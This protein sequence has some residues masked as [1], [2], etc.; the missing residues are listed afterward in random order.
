MEKTSKARNNLKSTESP[1][2]DGK[3][4][5]AR[6]TSKARENLKSTG[7]PQKHGKPLKSTGKPQKH[8][9][10]SIAREKN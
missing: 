4:S 2:K 8:G 7:K 3:P 5:K 10:T 9:K 6:K 1:Q